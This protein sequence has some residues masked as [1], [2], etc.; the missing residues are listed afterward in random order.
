MANSRAEEG[1]KID[2]GGSVAAGRA[3][4][5]KS[6]AAGKGWW[7]GGGVDAAVLTMSYTENNF[8]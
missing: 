8:I 2:R 5:W 1:W 6:E 4:G 7:C 3:P